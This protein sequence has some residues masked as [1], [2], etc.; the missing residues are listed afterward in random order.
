MGRSLGGPRLVAPAVCLLYLRG[1]ELRAG[2]EPNAI[3]IVSS[4]S[5]TVAD[6]RKRVRA[7]GV[8]EGKR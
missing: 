5:K 2:P 8:T 4:D 7:G 1:E 3:D 6:I